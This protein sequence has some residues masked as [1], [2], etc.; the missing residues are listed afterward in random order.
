[1]QGRGRRGGGEPLPLVLRLISDHSA[2][3]YLNQPAAPHNPLQKLLCG[4]YI[5]Y[6]IKCGFKK[7]DFKSNILKTCYFYKSPHVYLLGL[8]HLH[9]LQTLDIKVHIWFSFG[10]YCYSAVVKA[11]RGHN[12]FKKKIYME[13]NT[14]KK[15]SRKKESKIK[16]TEVNGQGLFKSESGFVRVLIK[17]TKKHNHF[18]KYQL[19]I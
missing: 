7:S 13:G 16:E 10:V 6:L 15:V 5:V 14:I 17:N 8:S 18:L 1:M 11:H 19:F 2:V 4:H 3:C 9:L 12:I